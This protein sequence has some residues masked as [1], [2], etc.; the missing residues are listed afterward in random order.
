MLCECIKRSALGD[1]VFD[2]ASET[3]TTVIRG[4]IPQI[5]IPFA[6]SHE[7][8]ATD[9][10]PFAVKFVYKLKFA[11]TEENRSKIIVIQPF[12]R[13]LHNRLELFFRH[14]PLEVD[15]LFCAKELKPIS[16]GKILIVVHLPHTTF[17]CAARTFIKV[18]ANTM[19]FAELV[20]VNFANI[21]LHMLYS[22]PRL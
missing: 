17:I 19:M 21:N 20:I 1:I 15:V 13:L 18:N 6:L 16:V 3:L 5:V 12:I 22:F 10:C 8:I 9:K 2:L 11:V 4:S 7:Q 14:I